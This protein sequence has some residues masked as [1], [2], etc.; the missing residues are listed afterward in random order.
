MSYTRQMAE[1]SG[2][3]SFLLYFAVRRTGRRESCS[4]KAQAEGSHRLPPTAL[5]LIY[6]QFFVGLDPAS[7]V[8]L[9]SVFVA[10]KR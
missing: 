4:Q 6:F 5:E 7:G 2:L 8:R 10:L 9:G 3:R 1:I